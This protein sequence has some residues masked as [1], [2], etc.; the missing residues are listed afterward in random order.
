MCAQGGSL[1]IAPRNHL[2]TEAFFLTRSDMDHL[3][4]GL[5]FA[6]RFFAGVCQVLLRTIKSE[7]TIVA[8][9]QL[10]LCKRSVGT[11]DGLPELSSAPSHRDE[12]DMI[13]S[14]EVEGLAE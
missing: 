8:G 12:I 9:R 1:R 3:G 4:F 6:Q 11:A 7:H 14:A 13:L 10:L 5:E 2:Q